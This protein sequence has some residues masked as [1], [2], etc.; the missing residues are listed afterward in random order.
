MEMIQQQSRQGRSSTRK[1]SGA[2]KRKG[3][4]ET[5]P[6]D[7]ED[8]TDTD[9]E[10]TASDVDSQESSEAPT[11]RAGVAAKSKAMLKPINVLWNARM[12]K[13]MIMKGNVMLA[14]WT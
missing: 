4:D 2:G 8:D 10:C 13:P 3:R 12:E 11:R 1:E 5:E 7:S 6:S 14:V 9:S